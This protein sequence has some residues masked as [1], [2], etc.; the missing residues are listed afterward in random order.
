V[1]L[2]LSISVLVVDLR[3][4]FR[5][6]TRTESNSGLQWL[7]NSTPRALLLAA[8]RRAPQFLGWAGQ[9]F[10]VGGQGPQRTNRH[11]VPCGWLRARMDTSLGPRRP[12]QG[13]RRPVACSGVIWWGERV[14]KTSTAHR[15]LVGHPFLEFCRP[16]HGLF[17]GNRTSQHSFGRRHRP[18]SEVRCEVVRLQQNVC[19]LTRIMLRQLTPTVSLMKQVREVVRRGRRG[20]GQLCRSFRMR[21]PVSAI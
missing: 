2:V 17:S 6:P 21:P 8:H 18:T 9:L 1:R 10:R 16:V 15:V 12:A 4:N 3:A 11:G 19:R 20:D 7:K 14:G 13:P 5:R